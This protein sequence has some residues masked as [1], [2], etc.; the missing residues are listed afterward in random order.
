[1]TSLSSKAIGK[2]SSTMAVMVQPLGSLT[3]RPAKVIIAIGQTAS[4]RRTL[5]CHETKNCLREISFKFD[6]EDDENED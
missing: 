4:H 5:S 2:C 1:P 6:D 3:R